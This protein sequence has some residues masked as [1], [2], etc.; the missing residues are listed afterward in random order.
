LDKLSGG[1]AIANPRLA[2]YGRAAQQT[3]K[4]L[5]VWQSKQSQIRTGESI[6]QAY[7]LVHSGA[8]ESGFVALSQLLRNNIPKA[9]YEIVSNNYHAPISQGVILLKHGAE[10]ES[11]P[12][13]ICFLASVEAQTVIGNDGYTQLPM[14]FPGCTE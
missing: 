11:A 12:A 4:N 9:Q 5:G 10:N 8:V 14:N 2:P 7:Q 6:S 1:I 13:F 3:L